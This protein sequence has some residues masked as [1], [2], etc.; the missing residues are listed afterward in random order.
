MK[1][2]C[3]PF[4]VY[5]IKINQ[6]EYLPLLSHKRD[7]PI[8]VRHFWVTVPIC[9]P[10]MTYLWH[11]WCTCDWLMTN[12]WS[13][14]NQ[15]VTPSWSFCDQLVIHLWPTCVS[16]VAFLLLTCDCMHMELKIV[17]NSL[18]NCAKFSL[19]SS[20]IFFKISVKFSSKFE[21]NFL[22]NCLIFS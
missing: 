17:W 2:S 20:E 13:T 19:R 6:S 12:L 7:Q 11:M 5:I 14:C 4:V 21:W 15:L 10:I 3:N 22:S 9:D 18:K 1:P 16:L 8:N